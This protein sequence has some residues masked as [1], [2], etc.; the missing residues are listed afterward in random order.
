M[1][2]LPEAAFTQTD[3][4]RGFVGESTTGFS[5]P[6]KDKSSMVF[7]PLVGKMFSSTTK[8][9]DLLKNM[10]RLGDLYGLPLTRSE[11]FNVGFTSLSNPEFDR[12]V[13]YS[14]IF[15]K[16]KSYRYII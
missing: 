9:R 13:A 12:K 2:T 4:M 6:I 3:R 15:F 8:S 14:A 11:A 16:D 5:L 10:F 1:L 7:L